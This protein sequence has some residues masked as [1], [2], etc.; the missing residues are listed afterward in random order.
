MAPLCT[1]IIGAET[2]YLV[3]SIYT[4]SYE[5][6]CELSFSRSYPLG[7]LVDRTLV[8]LNDPVV[9]INTVRFQLIYN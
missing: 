9:D 6:G 5:H 8:D 2:S 7:D 4:R 3:G 1:Y